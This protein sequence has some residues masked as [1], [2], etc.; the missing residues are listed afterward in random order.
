MQVLIIY[1]LV[2]FYIVVICFHMERLQTGYSQVTIRLSL[3]QTLLFQ[4]FFT[5]FKK[6]WLESRKCWCRK[7]HVFYIAI[8]FVACFINILLFKW[9]KRQSCLFKLQTLLVAL[10]LL[11]LNLLRVLIAENSNLRCGSAIKGY[12]KLFVV[13]A[14]EAKTFCSSNRKRLKVLST[15]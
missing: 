6:S 11:I 5:R 14:R 9:S 12:A 1:F 7:F 2:A 4:A 10:P 13:G 8:P 3:R 15:F